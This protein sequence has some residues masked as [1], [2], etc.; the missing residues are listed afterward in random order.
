MLLILI[1]TFELF[2]EISSPII[3]KSENYRRKRFY[4]IGLS[5]EG[6]VCCKMRPKKVG[7][8]AKPKSK[9]TAPL[10]LE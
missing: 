3:F 6:F 9:P 4:V 2:I 7:K 5:D 8:I 1:F 10:H